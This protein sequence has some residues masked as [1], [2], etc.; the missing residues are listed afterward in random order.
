[1][2]DFKRLLAEHHLTI[3]E[4]SKRFAIPVR[5]AENWSNGTRSM[6]DYLM[7]LLR[8]GLEH[9][10]PPKQAYFCDE[11]GARFTAHPTLADLCPRCGCACVYPDTDDGRRQSINDLTAYENK[12][13]EQED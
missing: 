5:T 13:I 11:C 6:P 9:D 2:T 8:F 3:R 12:L 10:Y 7:P 1:M 4:F